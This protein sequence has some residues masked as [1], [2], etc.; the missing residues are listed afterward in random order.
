MKIA[1]PTITTIAAP[2]SINI[3]AQAIVSNI[4]SP[5]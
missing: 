5:L 2:D 1:T 4:L 3:T